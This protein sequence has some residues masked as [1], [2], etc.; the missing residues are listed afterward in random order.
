[1]IF[2]GNSRWKAHGAVLVLSAILLLGIVGIKLN[3]FDTIHEI[4]LLSV[5][6]V[7]RDLH[8]EMVRKALTTHDTR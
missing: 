2:A 8:S 1:M 3:S 6:D 4:D 7:D 5:H